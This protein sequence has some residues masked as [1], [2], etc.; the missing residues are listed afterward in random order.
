[1]K[2]ILSLFFIL[3]LSVTDIYL[4]RI[5]VLPFEPSLS[6]IPLLFLFSL[7]NKEMLNNLK[8]L[9]KNTSLIFFVFLFIIS[10]LY[11]IKSTYSDVQTSIGLVLLS[12]I[13]YIVSYLFFFTVS[14]KNILRIFLIAYII[15]G[16]S[17]IIELVFSQNLLTRGAGFAENPN[18][19]AL[20]LIILSLVILHL[21]KSKKHKIY[22]LFSL[23]ILS[24]LTL[25]RSGIL[26]SSVIIIYNLLTNFNNFDIKKLGIIVVKSITIL[27]LFFISFYFFSDYLIQNIPGFET[28]AAMERVNQIKGEERLFSE[29]DFSEGGRLTIFKN[30]YNLF[31]ENPYGYGTGTSSDRDFYPK[32]TH[33]TFLRLAIDF[34]FFGLIALFLYLFIALKKSLKSK[35][36]D[37]FIFFII[38]LIACVF[39][40]TLLENRTF[41]IGLAAIDF[42]RKKSISNYYVQKNI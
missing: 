29:S 15:L 30:Y 39:T 31:L 11:S 36:L 3:L 18:N 7:L 14:I 33:N 1:M 6:I 24:F 42:Y 10:I 13:L 28:R 16:S 40:N 35:N 23:L 25:S 32:A 21:I 9:N 22:L 12:I 27:I 37:S 20:R 38:I 34:G 8:V 2:T 19:A 17:V 4:Y 5:E 41:L 26:M